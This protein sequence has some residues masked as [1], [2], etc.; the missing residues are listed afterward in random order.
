MKKQN[1]TKNFLTNCSKESLIDMIL[2]YEKSDVMIEEFRKTY[3]HNS[4]N[5]KQFEKIYERDFNNLKQFDDVFKLSD[6]YLKRRCID[7]FSIINDPV[8]LKSFK[9][10]QKLHGSLLPNGFLV[11]RKSIQTFECSQNKTLWDSI[12]LME[13]KLNIVL[14]DHFKY[15]VSVVDNTSIIT[16]T[17]WK[18]VDKDHHLDMLK[19]MGTTY[20]PEFMARKNITENEHLMLV[21]VIKSLKV[22]IG[23]S[24]GDKMCR[25]YKWDYDDGVFYKYYE[26]G[27]YEFVSKYHKLFK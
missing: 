10:Q 11:Q 14:P 20:I 22:Y 4:N 3:K 6:K 23:W 26:H 12:G 2:S 8:I 16:C 15:W 1:K 21:F 7:E 5:L 17:D 9:H 24:E 18:L 25:F 19:R 13:R 27:I